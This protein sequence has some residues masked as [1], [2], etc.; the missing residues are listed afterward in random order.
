VTKTS[1]RTKALRSSQPK[2]KQAHSTGTSCRNTRTIIAPK[3][4][5]LSGVYG[6][7]RNVVRDFLF[8]GSGRR[9]MGRPTSP[10]VFFTV[11]GGVGMQTNTLRS[12]A[13]MLRPVQQASSRRGC[14]ASFVASLLVRFP[15]SGLAGVRGS[16]RTHQRASYMLDCRCARGAPL[17]DRSHKPGERV[18]FSVPIAG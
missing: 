16:R 12:F 15:A 5:P 2:W 17:R 7:L 3:P 11:F 8:L 9:T 6:V 18:L 14:P 13:S 1:A 4:H 10:T